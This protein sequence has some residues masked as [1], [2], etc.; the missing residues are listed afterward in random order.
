VLSE[1][2]L[3]NGKKRI[4]RMNRVSLDDIRASINKK[5]KTQM[6][7]TGDTYQHFDRIPF[8][9]PRLNYLTRGG[10]PWPGATE[11]SGPESS[12]KTTI[13]GDLV[14]N[15]QRMGLLCA[16]TDTEN[17]TDLDYWKWIGVDVDNLL[18]CKPVNTSGESILE[19][20][21]ELM[22]E[23]VSFLGLDSVASLVP[24][25]VLTGTMDDKTYAGSSG[26][27]ST[28]S[29][30]LTGSGILFDKK[31]CMVGV[32]QVRDVM[33][34]YGLKTPGGHFWRH[35]CLCRLQLSKGNPFDHNHK[36][37]AMSTIEQPSGHMVEIRMLKNQFSKNDRRYT[38]MTFDYEIG[39]DVYE[40]AIDVGLDLEIVNRAGAWYRFVNRETGEIL[41]VNGDEIK[42]QGRNAVNEYFKEN[43]RIFKWVMGQI[44]QYITE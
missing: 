28:F 17:K 32:N 22:R 30:K 14:K 16:F 15:A 27:L 13:L 24:K 41:C 20:Q 10:I 5:F 29:Q 25:Q 23:G 36:E 21:F 42:L 19:L 40:D 33:S 38:T 37:M 39:V 7:Q 9:S 12:G 35:A 3:E 8:S 18:L 43:P 34:G 26:I 31:V 6:I 44:S 11:L 4:E 2:I 1:T